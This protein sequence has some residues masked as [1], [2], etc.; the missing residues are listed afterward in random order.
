MPPKS[1]LLLSATTRREHLQQNPVRASKCSG[2]L[3]A[4]PHPFRGRSMAHRQGSFPASRRS[5]ITILGGAAAAWPLAARAQQQAIPVIGY[6]A[7]TGVQPDPIEVAPFRKGLN[8]MGYVEGL[9]V[10]IEFRATD[11]YDRL[12]ALAADL[13]RR[14]VAVLFAEGPVN[15]ARA[16]MEATARIPIVFATGGDPVS[17]GLVASM[18]KPGGR[19]APR[20]ALP[21][22]HPR[23]ASQI[24]R[25]WR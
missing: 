13:V 11:K 3:R 9:N 12:P 10:A 23:A 21:L 22:P 1:L 24:R 5:F 25:L 16:A 17:L 19:A 2:R 15:A 18:N 14:Q 20:P 4:T 6:L 8:D 7:G